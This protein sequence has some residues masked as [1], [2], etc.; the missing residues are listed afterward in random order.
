MIA[1]TP[2]ERKDIA[3]DIAM[4]ILRKVPRDTGQYAVGHS[5]FGVNAWRMTD[6]KRRIRFKYSFDRNDISVVMEATE[7]VSHGYRNTYERYKEVATVQFTD[8][9]DLTW[10]IE[11][12]IT[13][14]AN[15]ENIA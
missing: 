1:L 6:D 4:R 14:A 12:F 10:A 3:A 8:K 7:T 11:E 5:Q 2:L 13:R 15:P 9:A